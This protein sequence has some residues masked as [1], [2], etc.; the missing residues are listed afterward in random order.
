MSKNVSVDDVRKHE[1]EAWQGAAPLYSDFIAPFTAHSGQIDLHHEMSPIEKGQLVLD[2]GSGTGDVAIQLDRAG[3]NVT[4]I[5]FAAEMV[6]V[7]KQRHPHINFIEADVES[8]PFEN[9]AFDRAIANYT[10]HHFAD[11]ESAFGEIRRVLKPGGK[12]TIIHPIQTEQPSWGAFA[13]SLAEAVPGDPPIGG[14][15]LMEDD[16][17]SYVDFLSAAGFAEANSEKRTKP[18]TMDTLEPI[19]R[20]GWAVGMMDKQPQA[21][22]DQVL[23][24]IEE[25]TRPFRLENGSYLFPDQVLIAHAIA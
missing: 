1:H 18:I 8:L 15:L 3:A 12:L 5:D 24:G 22:Q 21:I 7:A 20:G 2:V 4:G 13:M 6:E 25:R 9:D 10:A 16:P 19:I 23:A 17:A 14:P 11:P